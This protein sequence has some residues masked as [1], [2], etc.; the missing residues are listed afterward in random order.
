MI[1]FDVGCNEGEYYNYC[2][3]N[4]EG[5]KVVA[6]DANPSMEPTNPSA[7]LIFVNAI[8]AEEDDKDME[9]FID[10]R[11]TGISTASKDWIENSRFGKGSALLPPHSG[12]WDYS[13]KGTTVTLD[14]LVERFGSPDIIKIDVEG[15]ELEALK[16]LSTKQGMVTFEWTE[17][18]W[19]TLCECV[20]ELYSIGYREFSAA[21]YISSTPYITQDPNA[22]SY[23]LVP[24]H[25][26]KKEQILGSLALDINEDR[27]INY[28]MFF[29]K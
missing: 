2:F 18:G 25:W 21:A 5:C 27:R 19:K 12:R 16:G 9:F 29:A 4:F 26:D 22:D 24:T 13:I 28:G 1:I 14:T 15:F 3:E 8:I 10:P 11:Q 17:E 6:V 20:E 7:R 23:G